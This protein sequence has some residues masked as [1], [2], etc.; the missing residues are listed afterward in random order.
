MLN[1]DQRR[2]IDW[3]QE[4]T[5][6]IVWADVGTG[7]TVCAITALLYHINQLSIGKIL[8]VAPRLVAERVWLAETTEWVELRGLRV[9]RIIG[10]PRERIAALQRDADI[11]TISRDNIEWLH[12]EFIRVTGT[13]S[14]GNPIRA[15]YR[16]FP[17][18]A[19][20]LD[21]SQ[22]FKSQSAKRTKAV[23]RLR[24]LVKYLYLLSGSLMPNGYEDLWSQVYLIDSGKRLGTSENAFHARW[25][26]KEVNDGLVTYGLRTGAKEEIDRAI[27]DICIVMRDMQPAAPRNF[28]KVRLDTAEQKLYSK[29]VRES[30]IELGDA[31]INAVNAGVLWG[32]LLQ[33]ANGAVYDGERNVH[34][35]HTKKLDALLETLE[36]ISG[37][38]IVGYGFVHDVDRICAALVAAGVRGVGIL[39]TN[40]SLDDWRAGRIRIGIM[41]PASA[42]HGLND[43]YVSGAENLIWFGLT[44]NRE[45]YEQLNGR[46]AGGHRRTGKKFAFTTSCARIRTTRTLWRSWTSKVKK[47]LRRR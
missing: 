40:R 10:S 36:S 31:K 15:Q 38:V 2:V 28:I 41:H 46:L 7:K 25:F 35:L 4:R 44:P 17:F 14:K 16:K 45:F 20:V 30:V 34:V 11:Y 39:R 6:G 26:T 27:S 3:M 43:L 12:D 8:V 23:R 29:M 18:D 1:D 5:S 33:M 37:P 19:L 13:D 32:K 9:S 47:P 24:L 21:E 42:G 22:S